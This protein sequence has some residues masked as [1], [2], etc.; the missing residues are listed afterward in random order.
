MYKYTR[1]KI[2]SKLDLQICLKY[3]DNILNIRKTKTTPRWFTCF[4]QIMWLSLII[5]LRLDIAINIPIPPVF[6][7]LP[8]DFSCLYLLTLTRDDD[9]SFYIERAV[10]QTFFINKSW[11][12]SQNGIVLNSSK[13]MQYC[14]Q[15]WNVCLYKQN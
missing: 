9:L 2:N 10:T 5:V 3:Y 13:L 8:S 4:I 15:H 14:V 7:A 12:I 1:F 6:C 11:H